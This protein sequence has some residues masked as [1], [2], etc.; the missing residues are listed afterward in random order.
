MLEADL[1]LVAMGF[2][3]PERNPIV[4]NLELEEDGRGNLKVSPG[5]MTGVAGVFGAGDMCLGQSL[6]VK[7]IADGR[8]AA[9][10]IRKY[11]E[12]I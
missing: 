7:A 3:R 11:L 12:G 2:E 8:T 5:G 1:V 6:V 4:E 9:Q 10:G